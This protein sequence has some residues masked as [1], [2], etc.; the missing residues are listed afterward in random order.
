MLKT[1]IFEG[2]NLDFFRSKLV[3]RSKFS[4]FMEKMVF[5]LNFFSCKGCWAEKTLPMNQS[6]YLF[7]M[8]QLQNNV[9]SFKR[10]K[11]P[12]LDSFFFFRG[13][14]HP[15]PSGCGPVPQLSILWSAPLISSPFLLKKNLEKLSVCL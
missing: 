3:F 8:F 7:R 6:E 2:Q 14:G 10:T 4:V 15:T 5:L 1:L 11:G 9:S 12:S 13:F